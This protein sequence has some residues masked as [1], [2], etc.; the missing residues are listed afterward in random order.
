MDLV[1]LDLLDAERTQPVVDVVASD[2][3]RYYAVQRPDEPTAVAVEREQAALDDLRSRAAA[4]AVV[5]MARVCFNEAAITSRLTVGAHLGPYRIE[6]LL[7]AGGMGQ[8]Y[9]AR[10]SGGDWLMRG[11]AT[12]AAMKSTF[13]PEKLNDREAEGTITYTFKP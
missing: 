9:K 10:G 6:A 8:V 2:L 11:C 5:D 7:G 12:E 13:D 3:A 1:T 4:V